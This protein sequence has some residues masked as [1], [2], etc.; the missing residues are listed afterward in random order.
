M[1]AARN[2]RTEG[3][4]IVLNMYRVAV[5]DDEQVPEMESGSVA[6]HCDYI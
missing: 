4:G 1:V 3:C 2:Y 6:Q 5:W